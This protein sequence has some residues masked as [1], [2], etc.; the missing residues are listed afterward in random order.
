M[1]TASVHDTAEA[2]TDAE[3]TAEV[4]IADA[5]ALAIRLHRSANLD[6]AEMIYRRVLEAVPDQPDALNF[7]GVLTHQRSDSATAVELIR[8]SIAIDPSLPDRHVNLGNILAECGQ[9]DKAAEA[10]RQAIA[11]SPAPTPALANAWNNLGAV[12]RTQERFD[13]AAQAYQKAIELA[14][15]H[16][17]AYNN[18]GNLLSIQGRTA[19]AV[20][21]YCKALT[22]S[23]RHAQSR[24]L[25]GLAYYTLGQIDEAS[26]VYREWLA[27]EPDNPVAQHMLSAC[28]GQDVPAR[29]SDAYVENTFDA[30][31]ESFDAKLARLDY[32]A[33][34]LVTDAVVRLV[35]PGAVLDVLDAGCGTGLC[36]PLLKPHALRL[37][38]VDLSTG[39]LKRA[40]ARNVYDDLEHGE[41]TA[42]LEAHPGAFDLVVSADTLVYFGALEAVLGAAAT[43]LRPGGVLAFTVEALDDESA[44]DYRINPHGRYS[45]RG[46][47]V[48]RTLANAGF[49]DIDIAPA[50]LRR[51]GGKP[52]AGLVVTCRS[53]T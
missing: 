50:E 39:M 35:A 8:H 38:G 53:A 52:V 18:H 31:A 26:R 21:S 13:E 51:E 40:A 16:A 43:C 24:K 25:L 9:L 28:S 23:P 29:A 22:V 4:S 47:Y 33:P 44:A 3:T 37:V 17:D 27:D 46:D 42:Y 15:D 7:L 11:C 49:S 2:T 19:E 34:Q 36:G 32:R 14:P 12:L 6:A 1:Q 45:H 5:L 20:A 30:F 10:Y 48:R 41:L